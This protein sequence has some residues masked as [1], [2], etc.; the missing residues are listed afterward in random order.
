MLPWCAEETSKPSATYEALGPLPQ[1]AIAKADTIG[2]ADSMA[3][4]SSTSMYVIKLSD[5]SFVN[6]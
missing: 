5:G 2:L 6:C 3:S 1:P 4:I